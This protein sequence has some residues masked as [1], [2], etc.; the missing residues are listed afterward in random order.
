MLAISVDDVRRVIRPTQFESPTQTDLLA[1]EY[2]IDAN[3]SQLR[4]IGEEFTQRV[5]GARDSCGRR[6]PTSPATPDN[7][8]S[9]A[10]QNET[11]ACDS[12][13]GH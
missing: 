9:A 3:Y 13:D 5:R 10:L 11:P 2:S 6:D 1:S 7:V 12:S 4:E 8:G